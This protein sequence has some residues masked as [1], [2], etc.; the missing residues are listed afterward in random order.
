M[1]EI[2]ELYRKARF[3]RNIAFA[4]MLLSWAAMTV[5][6]CVGVIVLTDYMTPFMIFAL[7]AGSWHGGIFRAE[8]PFL[9]KRTRCLRGSDEGENVR[10]GNYAI[11]SRIKARYENFENLYRR[12]VILWKK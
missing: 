10:R 2:V 12:S 8:L 4:A 7:L 9:R 5:L 11:G 1:D 3:R 6:I